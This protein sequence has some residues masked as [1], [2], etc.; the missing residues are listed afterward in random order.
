[1]LSKSHLHRVQVAL[2]SLQHCMI[3]HRSPLVQ[4][5]SEVCDVIG[6]QDQDIQLGELCV[7]RN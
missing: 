4:C 1:M 3:T 7:R 2:S 6:S 5:L